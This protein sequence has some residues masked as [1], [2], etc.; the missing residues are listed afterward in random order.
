MIMTASTNEFPILGTPPTMLPSSSPESSSES[1]SWPESS[2]LRWVD[3]VAKERL[4]AS[5]CPSCGDPVGAHAVDVSVWMPRW[6]ELS[7][8]DVQNL[9]VQYWTDKQ[10]M[11]TNSP[12]APTPGSFVSSEPQ[13]SSLPAN[14]PWAEFLAD[15]AKFEAFKAEFE[16]SRAAAHEQL[17]DALARE[18]G[19]R[20]SGSR[21][22]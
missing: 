2:S 16:A 12:P 14:H 10:T 22:D 7:A 19:T 8:R 1:G 5:R 3:V 13:K 4:H 20:V 6:C 21:F 18:G 17:K 15:D 11:T 9:I